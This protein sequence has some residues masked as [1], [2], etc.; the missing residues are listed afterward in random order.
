VRNSN[1]LPNTFSLRNYI[2]YISPH[3][4]LRCR[5]FFIDAVDDHYVL[6]KWYGT[7]GDAPINGLAGLA[8]L[9]LADETQTKSFD[10]MPVNSIING[11][12][13]VNMGDHAWAMQ[14][15]RE[16]VEYAKCLG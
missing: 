10:I 6:V 8:S 9:K 3:K 11:A 15:P 16:A 12:L 13:V 5:A 7:V 1:A 4:F 2:K 14:S